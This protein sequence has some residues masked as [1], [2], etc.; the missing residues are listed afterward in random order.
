MHL[1]ILRLK[2]GKYYIGTTN[3]DVTD[4]LQEH[5]SGRGSSWTIKYK[6]LRLEKTIENCDKY[7]EDKWTKIYMDRHGITNVRGGSYCEMTLNTESIG[8]ISREVSHANN[9]CLYCNKKG[10]FIRDCPN[11]TNT[12][13]KNYSKNYSKHLNYLNMSC[14]YESESESDDYASDDEW[15]ESPH[16]NIG[17]RDGTIYDSELGYVRQKKQ[18]YYSDKCFKWSCSYCSKNF[19][20]KKG[21][22]YHENIYCKYNPNTKSR[23]KSY[24]TKSKKTPSNK[25]FKCGRNGHYTSKCYAKKHIKGYYL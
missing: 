14:D 13:L 2:Q 7:D 16:D 6:V 3:K 9:K 25:C 15:E 4:R 18:N 11:K 8:C 22:T 10:H 20:T 5:M 17:A 1:Y 23:T 21:A 12:K 24:V 19:D